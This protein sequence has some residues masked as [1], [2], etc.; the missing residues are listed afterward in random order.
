V[1]SDSNFFVKRPDA[2]S[3]Q[4][5]ALDAKYIFLIPLVRSDPRLV[6]E[7]SSTQAVSILWHRHRNCTVCL[8]FILRSGAPVL[9]SAYLPQNRNQFNGPERGAITTWLQRLILFSSKMDDVDW[10]HI[11]WEG[12][13]C[14]YQSILTASLPILKVYFN[15]KWPQKEYVPFLN[16]L[17]ERGDDHGNLPLCPPSITFCAL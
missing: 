9:C 15:E 14:V 2:L 11:E 12:Y 1:I 3:T 13:C 16:G 17:W 8:A 4:Q 6:C 10:C 7:V 5:E